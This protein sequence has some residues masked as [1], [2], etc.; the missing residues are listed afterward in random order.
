MGLECKLQYKITKSKYIF[1]VL[2]GYNLNIKCNDESVSTLVS[3]VLP[4]F[5]V[6]FRKSFD[7]EQVNS[8]GSCSWIASGSFQ[9]NIVEF[10]YSEI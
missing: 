2:L 8:C 6:W 10:I 7:I 5:V 4:I 9:I 1:E 3:N